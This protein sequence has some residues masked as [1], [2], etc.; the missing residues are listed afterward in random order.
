MSGRAVRERRAICTLDV[1][2]EPDLSV[3]PSAL[4]ASEGAAALAAVPLRAGVQV[5]GTLV[6]ADRPG[7]RYTDQ[8]LALLSFFGDQAVLL[9]ETARVRA[10]PVQQREE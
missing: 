9:F 6:L 2:A 7:R 5:V 8:E 1:F 4:T 10:G 3:E